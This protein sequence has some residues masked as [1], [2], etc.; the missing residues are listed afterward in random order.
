MDLNSDAEELVASRWIVGPKVADA[1][2]RAK[3][4]KS[5]GI[6]SMVNYLGENLKEIEEIMQ[7]ENLYYDLIDKI[8]SKRLPVDISLKPTQLG[9]AI[10]Y[11]IFAK[12]YFNLVNYAYSKKVFVWLDMEENKYV[13][14]TIKAY[15]RI[16][17][18]GNVG[19]CLQAYL[20]R[21][22]ND[23]KKLAKSN[24]RIRLV[25]GAYSEPS[26]IAY[27]SWADVTA[28]YNYLM[29]ILFSKFNNF[30]LATHDS[31]I[32]DKALLLNRVLKRDVSY[33]LLNGIRNKYAYKLAKSGE[34]VYLY[35]PFGDK[36]WI[37]YAYRRL[38]EASHLKLFI[39]SLF[40]S[41]S[42]S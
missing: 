18:K 33:A 39:R 23:L 2:D 38:K 36:K 29:T 32:M 41:Q 1:L 13:D 15:T 5:L 27:K 42:L 31:N 14:S 40:E 16:V 25:K 30:V 19:I 4:L 9:L 6:K 21:T 11:G 26:S 20:K 34:S 7:T 3:K 12:N 24:S 37:Y 17:K 28:N 8:H 22:E 35:L 10:D